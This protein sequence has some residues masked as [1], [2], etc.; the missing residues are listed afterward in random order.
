MSIR[1]DI[2]FCTTQENICWLLIDLQFFFTTLS[3]VLRIRW[4]YPLQKD[5]TFSLQK[6]IPRYVTK[7]HLMVRIQFW[8]SGNCWVLSLLQLFSCP[9]WP[10]FFTV[11]SMGVNRSVCKLFVFDNNVFRIKIILK[12]L[13]PERCEYESDSLGMKCAVEF[14]Q[15]INLFRSEIHWKNNF[16]LPQCQTKK[17]ARKIQLSQCQWKAWMGV[18]QGRVKVL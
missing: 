13:L 2:I 3:S 8:R 18:L 15:L 12:K 11:I 9:L 17:K 10:A 14:N 4:L 7:L 5:K 6:E 16:I 1:N